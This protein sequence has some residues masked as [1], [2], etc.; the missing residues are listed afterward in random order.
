M[1]RPARRGVQLER[2]ETRMFHIPAAHAVQF[3]RWNLRAAHFAHGSANGKLLF[4][5]VTERSY[6]RLGAGYIEYL[7]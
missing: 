4:A 6:N 3:S 2:F 7:F 5:A 1:T